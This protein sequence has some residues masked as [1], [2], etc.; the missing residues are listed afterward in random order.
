MFEHTSVKLKFNYMSEKIQSMTGKI[1]RVNREHIRSYKD[2]VHPYDDE[3][4]MVLDRQI[5]VTIYEIVDDEGRIIYENI[6]P[7]D[8]VF[9]VVFD[10]YGK[11]LREYTQGREPYEVNTDDMKHL[12]KLKLQG[13]FSSEK[14][15][16]F[17]AKY[18][19][20][21]S[22]VTA[23]VRSENFYNNKYMG[24]DGDYR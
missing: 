12:L 6:N 22:P 10:F 17:E 23:W 13:A 9:D 24:C 2:W 7:M 5:E 1:V 14:Y 19:E 20:V 8:S 16:Y 21:V 15:N 18:F 4:D 3:G 11:D